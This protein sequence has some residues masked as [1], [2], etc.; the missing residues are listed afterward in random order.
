MQGVKVPDKPNSLRRL[1]QCQALGTNLVEGGLLNQ[2]HLW[3]LE[4]AVIKEVQ[5]IYQL[6]QSYNDDQ[7][8]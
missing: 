8:S 2:P 1:E 7:K 3:L 4:V 6:Q 5:T